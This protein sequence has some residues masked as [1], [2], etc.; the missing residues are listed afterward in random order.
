[1]SQTSTAPTKAASPLGV[2]EFPLT[3]GSAAGVSL[4]GDQCTLIAYP[5][6]VLQLTGDALILGTVMA[7]MGIPRALFMLIG[8]ALVDRF[9]PRTIMLVTNAAAACSSACWPRSR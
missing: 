6:L 7:L 1:M 5:W 4:L 9:S 3:L 2:R 8:G